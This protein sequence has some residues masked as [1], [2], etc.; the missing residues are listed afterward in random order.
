M[1]DTSATDTMIGRYDGKI[2]DK[3]SFIEQLT[4]KAEVENRSLT[5]T[6]RELIEQAQGEVRVAKTD[7]DLYGETAKLS[8]ESRQSVARWDAALGAERPTSHGP[9]VEYRSAGQYLIDMWASVERGDVG[10]AANAR[11]ERFTIE[12]RA[13]AHQTTTDNPGVIPQIVLD[14]V[15]NFV[16]RARPLVSVLGP[17]PIPGGP[18]F[19]RPK[20]TQHTQVGAQSAEKAELPSRKML[21]TRNAVTITTYGGYVNVARQDIDWSAPQIMDLVIEDLAGEYATQT[22]TALS[23]AVLAAADTISGV[24]YDT[25]TTTKDALYAM[26]W[27]AVGQVYAATKNNGTVFLAISADRLGLIGPLL[28]PLSPVNPGVVTGFNAAGFGQGVVGSIGGIP[29]V[30]DATLAAAS[31]IVMSTSSVEVYDQR[32]GTLQVIEPSVLGVQVAYFGY[33]AWYLASTGDGG[34]IV[35]IPEAP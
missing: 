2:R 19:Y 31:M 3:L 25:G 18:T 11:L 1:G 26:I 29:V 30:V 17:K 32:G 6:E 28:N 24:A 14:P 7:L 33:F 27:T 23:A 9:A 22:E 10:R 34:G 4:S 12:T 8:I 35:S 5:D 20:V 16:D 21:I 15:I 13:A